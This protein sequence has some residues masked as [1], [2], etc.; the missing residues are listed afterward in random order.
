MKDEFEPM[1]EEEMKRENEYAKNKMAIQRIDQYFK[2]LSDETKLIRDL[3]SLPSM[4]DSRIEILCNRI[5][6]AITTIE[7]KR[8]FIKNVINKELRMEAA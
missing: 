3:I 6:D 5:G 7:V 1:S 8:N 2:E 4:D